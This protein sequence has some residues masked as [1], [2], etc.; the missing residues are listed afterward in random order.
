MKRLEMR[1]CHFSDGIELYSA[2]AAASKYKTP[3]GSSHS[4]LSLFYLLSARNEEEKTPYTERGVQAFLVIC[5]A[6]P[7]RRPIKI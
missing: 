7:P 6:P 3:R 5:L 2:T 1:V 4:H